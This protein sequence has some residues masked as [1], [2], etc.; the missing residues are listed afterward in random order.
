MSEELK[1]PTNTLL[2]CVQEAI[3]T[4]V[5][6]N[7]EN[8]IKAEVTQTL[9]N[10][11]DEIVRKLLGFTDKS[12]LW[13][14]DHFNGR[15][16]ESAA[17]DYLKRVSGDVIKQWFNTIVMPY[18]DY[19]LQEELKRQ[20]QEEYKLQFQSKMKTKVQ[21]LIEADLVTLLQDIKIHP[22]QVIAARKTLQD[23][24]AN[25]SSNIKENEDSGN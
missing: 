7:P 14:I 23:L 17:G 9:D 25:Q 21:S 11:K 13:E 5:N 15:Y 6:N 24:L 3:D 2:D 1:L 4:W 22:D 12:G 19:N 8:T 18:P 10:S 20:F 16:G